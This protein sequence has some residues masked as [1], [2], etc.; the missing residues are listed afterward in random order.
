MKTSQ[1]SLYPALGF[2][3]WI[4]MILGINTHELWFYGASALVTLFIVALAYVLMPNTKAT[5]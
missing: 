3:I 4:G 2:T 1:K 5:K